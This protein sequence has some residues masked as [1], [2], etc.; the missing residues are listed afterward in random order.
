MDGS[1]I[2][3]DICRARRAEKGRVPYRNILLYSEATVFKTVLT[4]FPEDHGH[5]KQLHLLQT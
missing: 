2:C 5:R 1:S 3:I 4:E